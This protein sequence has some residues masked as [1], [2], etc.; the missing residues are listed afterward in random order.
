MKF[1]ITSLFCIGMCSFILCV[2]TFFSTKDLP[3]VGPLAGMLRM[4]Q[5]FAGGVMAW[6]LAWLLSK[7]FL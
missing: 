3:D 2:H 7:A 5:F 1:F 4:V 6:L